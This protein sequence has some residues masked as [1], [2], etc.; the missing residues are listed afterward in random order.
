MATAT[1]R[2]RGYLKYVGA[3]SVVS[4]AGCLGEDSSDD[5]AGGTDD[6]E[7]DGD[8]ELEEHEVIV[9]PDGDWVFDPEEITIDVGDTVVWYFESPG[10]N[11]TSHPDADDDC[12][13]PEDAEP[14]TSYEG[15]NHMSV[16]EEGTEFEHTFDVPGEYV[17]V[18]TPH[19]PQMTGTVTVEE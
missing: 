3:I 1:P 13:N 11:V 2:R 7:S 19:T 15:D 5:G 10:H 9:G 6:D 12:E 4:L 8:S 18:C 16:N 17:Y 14:F